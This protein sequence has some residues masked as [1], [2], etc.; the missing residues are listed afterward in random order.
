MAVWPKFFKQHNENKE[1]VLPGYEMA[2]KA[3][4]K[5][6]Y[7]EW[8]GL[9]MDSEPTEGST[10]PITSGAVYNALQEQGGSSGGGGSGGGLVVNF[11]LE[12]GTGDY[13]G[14]YI[15]VTETPAADVIAA[16]KAGT[17]V[18]F[19]LPGNSEVGIPADHW[20]PVTAYAEPLGGATTNA[21]F[22]N[23]LSSQSSYVSSATIVDG[24]IIIEAYID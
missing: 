14:Y 1:P 16:I 21:P 19:Y 12:A 13:D 6:T 17:N 22:G 4:Y 15:W 18:V 20:I 10:N 5:G 9:K 8:L 11:T 3:G 24:E 2:V 7:E 23:L